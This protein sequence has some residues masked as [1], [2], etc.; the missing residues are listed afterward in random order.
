MIGKQLMEVAEFE[1]TSPCILVHTFFMYVIAKPN[2]CHPVSA[3][4]F[5]EKNVLQAIES[6]VKVFFDG[7]IFLSI[8]RTFFT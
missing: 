7:V 2:P 8:P 6:I 4:S 1:S 3:Q 5:H